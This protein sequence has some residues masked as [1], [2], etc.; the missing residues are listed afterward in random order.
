VLLGEIELKPGKIRLL[1]FE[2]AP[3]NCDRLGHLRCGRGGCC[4]GRP[5]QQASF[6]RFGAF[7]RQLEARD[8]R[9]VPGDAAKA[10][11]SFA[12]KIMVC[13]L[14]HHMALA[15]RSVIEFVEP[16]REF[17]RVPAF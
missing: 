3:Y 2:I 5:A 11:P 7:S 14:A 15:F 10:A 1:A 17:N 9:V 4:A 16:K 6:G 13:R 12:N 8:A